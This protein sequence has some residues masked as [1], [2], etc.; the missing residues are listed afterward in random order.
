VPTVLG[1]ELLDCCGGWRE[2]EKLRLLENESLP[3]HGVAF[4]AQELLRSPLDQEQGLAAA[5]THAKE[6]ETREA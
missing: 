3:P 6:E 1:Q 4:I 5:F 2:L